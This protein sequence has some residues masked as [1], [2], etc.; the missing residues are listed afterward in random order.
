[1][2]PCILILIFIILLFHYL[3]GVCINPAFG[4]ACFPG[5]GHHILIRSFLVFSFRV[6]WS[7]RH[8]ERKIVSKGL[9]YVRSNNS[10]SDNTHVACVS[11]SARGCPALI[12]TLAPDIHT[13][14]K[15][16][17]LYFERSTVLHPECG[18]GDQRGR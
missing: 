1:M 14:K 10:N 18:T 11:K 5:S 15:Q 13:F 12:P 9:I 17:I 2:F 3:D 8:Y 16:G 4:T 7:L 6:M